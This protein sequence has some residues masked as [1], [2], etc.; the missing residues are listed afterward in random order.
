[1]TFGK[2]V[3]VERKKKGY[4]Q[5]ELAK[6]VGTIS[7][8][9]GRYE[10]DEIKPSIDI[11]SKL[12]DALE[13]SLD[14]LTG[15]TDIEMDKDIKKRILE[16]FKFNDEDRASLYSVIDAFIAKRKIQSIL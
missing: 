2:K 7:V 1:M 13:V 14:Y 3:A 12:A 4:S 9:I 11:A 10:R 5:E 15:K 8:T 6:K 16:V